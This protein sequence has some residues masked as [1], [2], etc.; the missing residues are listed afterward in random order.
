MIHVTAHAISRYRERVRDIPA[1]EA[2]AL[3]SSPAISAA[4]DFG[5]PFVRL[6]TG[7]RICLVGRSVV[8]VLPADTWRGKLGSDRDHLHGRR[9]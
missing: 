7:Q 6:G 3:L 8:T 4:A 1:D 5:A 2:R 9:C